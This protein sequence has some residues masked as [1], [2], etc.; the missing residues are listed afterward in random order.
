MR[1]AALVVCSLVSASVPGWAAVE[2]GAATAVAEC[3]GHPATIVGTDGDDDIVGTAGD[4]VIVALAGLDYVRGRDGR[5]VICGGAD[6]DF[7]YG[8]AGRD[9]MYGGGDT[10]DEYGGDYVDGGPGHDTLWA[11]AEGPGQPV[12][13][14]GRYD[15]LAGQTGDDRLVGGPSGDQL[16]GGAGSDRFNGRDGDDT[17]HDYDTAGDDDIRGSGGLDTVSYQYESHPVTV[18][19]GAQLVTGAGTD[20]LLS[21]EAAEGGLGDDVLIGTAGPEMLAGG[22]YGADRLEGLGGDDLL[23]P[24]SSSPDDNSDDVIDGG[25]GLDEV[26]YS[27]SYAFDVVI[28]LAAG[29]ATNAEVGADSLIDIENATGTQNSDRLLGDSGD[30]TLNG[31]GGNDSIV[32]RVG[33]DTANGGDGTDRCDAEVTTACES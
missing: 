27:Q 12:S 3:A 26:D 7:F 6:G 24:V 10:D 23:L 30:N 17:L 28:D 22:P 25:P 15:R 4:D 33:V 21:I 14:G 8:D 9:Q 2:A 16:Y 5:D 18:D 1:M 32:G 31:A 29:T 11:D 13:A 19:L 20:T